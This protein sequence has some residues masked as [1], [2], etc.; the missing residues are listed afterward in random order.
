MTEET[1]APVQTDNAQAPAQAENAPQM[2]SLPPEKVE[3]WKRKLSGSKAEAMRLKAQAQRLAQEKAKLQAEL[4]AA[5]TGKPQSYGYQPTND[6]VELFRQL[7]KQAGIPLQEDLQAI[8]AKEYEK[9]KQAAI[10]EFLRSH[11]EY[12]VI[13]DDESDDLWSQLEQEVKGYVQ[14]KTG[15]GYLALMNKAHKTISYDAT[16][17]ME[18]GAALAMAQANLK[19]QGKI[20]GGGGSK[21]H[22]PQ[23]KIPNAQKAVTEGFAA[24]RPEAFNK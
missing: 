21:R 20:G 9:E 7:A 16:A 10:E 18:K 14:P 15:R 8:H 5:R 2:V 12:G 1:T 23:Q 11:P 19:E 6:E 17:H 24:I 22:E 13:G 4:E 3:D